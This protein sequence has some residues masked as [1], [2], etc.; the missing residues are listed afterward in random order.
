MILIYVNVN[1]DLFCKG[2][3]L[4][5][6]KEIDMDIKKAKEIKGGPMKVVQFTI[7]DQTNSALKEVAAKAGMTKADFLVKLVEEI[8][9]PTETVN[10]FGFKKMIG[11]N[12]IT[13][14]GTTAEDFKKD[15]EDLK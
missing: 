7:T 13:S 5:F 6:V 1:I 2:N 10:G 4:C 8:V 12:I 3:R 15:I 11:G 14:G 9:Y